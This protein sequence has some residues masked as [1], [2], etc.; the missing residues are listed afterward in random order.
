ML[1]RYQFGN[2]TFS[3]QSDTGMLWMLPPFN[4]GIAGVLLDGNTHE[5][6]VVLTDSG[7]DQLWN[8][9]AQG[10]D[11]ADRTARYRE[12]LDWMERPYA[13]PQ[14]KELDHFVSVEKDANTVL[15]AMIAF[16][17]AHPA[18]NL[19][20]EGMLVLLNETRGRR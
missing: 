12:M 14:V 8:D 6:S 1:D 3:F 9:A 2:W 5:L 11:R 10:G 17:I 15:G 19:C 18:G 16:A 13:I 4:C 20:P 7:K